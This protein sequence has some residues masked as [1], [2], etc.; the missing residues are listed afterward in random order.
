[1][2]AALESLE[3]AL[4]LAGDARVYVRPLGIA[5]GEAAAALLAANQALPLAGGPLVFATA[6]VILRRNGG[7]EYLPV[8][9]AALAARAKGELAALLQ[10]VCAPRHAWPWGG[11]APPWLM[12]IVNVTP[13]SF[14][15]GGT[16]SDAASAIKHAR[17]LAGRGASIVDIGGESTRPGAAPV[18]VEVELDRVRPVLEGLRAGRPVGVAL[19]I[20]T[21]RAA[22]MRQ[23]LELGADIINDVSALTSDGESL[24]VAAASNAAVILMHMPDEPARMNDAPRYDDVA[25]DVY[26]FLESRVVACMRAGIDRRRLIV[27][28]GIGFGK[29]G[30]HNIAVLEQIALYHGLGCPI[31]LGVSRKGLSEVHQKLS[32]RDRLPAAYAMAFHGLAQGVQLLR[33]HD[34]AETAQVAHIWRRLTA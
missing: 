28:P 20:D 26:D 12:G 3:R 4:S 13:D 31:M 5:S 6:L 14:S 19:S 9:A 25:L 10:R 27:D 22:V 8:P 32:P 17:A 16:L 7:R 11:G 30:P 34:V 29:L 18:P 21:R 2:I 24:K 15:D 23:A 1:M 33:V